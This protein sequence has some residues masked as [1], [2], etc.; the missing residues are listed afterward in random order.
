MEMENLKY[1]GGYLILVIISY[2]IL[3]ILFVESKDDHGVY[4]NYIPFMEDNYDKNNV[5]ENNKRKNKT[6]GIILTSVLSCFIP[7]MG[8][9]IFVTSTSK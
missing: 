6:T 7:I 1:L 5:K 4:A 2:I 8:Y 9:I 3:T